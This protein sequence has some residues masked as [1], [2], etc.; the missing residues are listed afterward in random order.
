[1]S[2]TKHQWVYHDARWARLREKALKRVG[3]R[4]ESCGVDVRGKYKARVDH[5]LA[6]SEFPRLAFELDNLRVLC[7]DC[8]ANRHSEKGGKV[9][10]KIGLDGLPIGGWK[11]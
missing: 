1:M 9:R 4:C 10:V 2:T 11:S 8:D 7:C 3:W 6:V 5:M